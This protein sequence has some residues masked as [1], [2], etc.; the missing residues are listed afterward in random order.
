MQIRDVAVAALFVLRGD[1]FAA[2]AD[3]IE[4][5]PEF[6]AAGVTRVDAIG[7]LPV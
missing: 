3:S 2:A 1:P 5:A 4:G 7:A 6:V